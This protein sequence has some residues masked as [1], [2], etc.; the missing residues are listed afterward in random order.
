[1]PKPDLIAAL[2]AA[3]TA[4]G[5]TPG[6]ARPKPGRPGI[7]LI[8]Q[9]PEPVTLRADAKGT[10]LLVD[11]LPF[12]AP[13][14]RLHRDVK[15]WLATHAPDA[16]CISR[17]GHLSLGLATNGDCTAALATL[18]ALTVDLKSALVVTWPDYANGVFA[19]EL[20]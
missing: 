17:N 5:L 16:L 6:T 18:L 13:G 4:Q 20:V 14:G 15:A 1:M 19:R 9:R 10:L 8:W 11:Y 3:V 2:R 12:V 7:T